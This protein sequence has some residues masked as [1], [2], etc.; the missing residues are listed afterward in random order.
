MHVLIL[1]HSGNILSRCNPSDVADQ[2]YTLP[3]RMY[4]PKTFYFSPILL[5]L[6]FLFIAAVV[7]AAS[8][9][10]A[11]VRLLL[12]A[13]YVPIRTVWCSAQ[14]A[15]NLAKQNVPD[16]YADTDNSLHN[17]ALFINLVGALRRCKGTG[18]LA[19]FSQ[20][21]RLVNRE[22]GTITFGTGRQVKPHIVPE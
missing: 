17:P 18:K 11:D 15:G 7:P 3:S 19:F 12:H 13:Y 14:A 20:I 22:I 5:E 8:D 10:V 6:G 2:I 9:V 4:L 1:L 21:H 16:S